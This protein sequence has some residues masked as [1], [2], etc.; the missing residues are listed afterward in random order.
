MAA[1]I[2]WMLVVC[3]DDL[4]KDGAISAVTRVFDALWRRRLRQSTI[5]D[6]II[7]TN[8]NAVQ[9]I[10]AAFWAFQHGIFQIHSR[11]EA[12]ATQ[13]SIRR[14]ICTKFSAGMLKRSAGSIEL[15][16]RNEN[17]CRRQ[18]ASRGLPL[19]A[20]TLSCSLK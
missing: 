6:K 3:V 1:L 5:L 11:P 8:S 18:A 17:S 20:T 4:V 19:R 7:N 2:A 16:D 14:L 15:R 12:T 10:K 9:A 13:T